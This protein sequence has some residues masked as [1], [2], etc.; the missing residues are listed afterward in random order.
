MTTLIRAQ[1]NQPVTYT[2]F[3]FGTTLGVAPTSTASGITVANEVKAGTI[4]RFIFTSTTDLKGFG[5]IPCV[6]FGTT[7]DVPPTTASALVNGSFSTATTVPFVGGST[8][9]RYVDVTIPSTATGN[10]TFT[11]SAN[12]MGGPFNF[13][14]FGSLNISKPITIATVLPIQLSAFNLSKNTEGVS[15]DWVTASEKN[16]DYFIVER[17]IN[18]SSFNAISTVKA[19]GNSLE[20][21]YYNFTDNRINGINSTVYYR[22]V[23]TD[24][25]GKTE[26]SKAISVV[27]GK[28]TGLSVKYIN[29]VENVIVLNS[30]TENKVNL[31]IVNVNGQVVKSAEL[32]ANVGENSFNFNDLNL[33]NGLYFIQLSN[34]AEVVTEKF[35]KAK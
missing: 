16:G 24:M 18:G 28:K 6:P 10:L 20:N 4:C 1:C 34:G 31:S 33:T 25:D 13:P 15:L 17:S 19:K 12:G 22:L 3:S 26:V 14:Y 30:E 32:R 11:V 23:S 21:S 2:L 9:Q 35:M 29:S 8:T 27:L 7:N 5:M